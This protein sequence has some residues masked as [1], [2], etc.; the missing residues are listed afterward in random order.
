MEFIHMDLGN[1]AEKD[2]TRLRNNFTGK[3][4]TSA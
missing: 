2:Q 3:M 1:A 4:K